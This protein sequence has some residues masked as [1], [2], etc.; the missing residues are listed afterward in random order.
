MTRTTSSHT[1]STFVLGALACALVACGGSSAESPP[2]A[3]PEPT[4]AAAP[5]D[6]APAPAAEPKES[7]AE[8]APAEPAKSDAASA[9]PAEKDVTREVKYV[10][11]SDGLKVEVEGT[12]FLVSAESKK[13]GAGWGVRV[14]VTAQAMDDGSHVLTN[15][16]VGPLAFA[17][18]VARGGSG[19]ATPEGEK[20]EG[21]GE[22]VVKKGKDVDF[23]RDWPGK[24]GKPLAIGDAIEIQMGLWGLGETK[25]TRRPVKKFAVVKMKVDKGTPRAKVEPPP[26]K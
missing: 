22:L 15:P 26:V 4:A 21:D 9:E 2:P 20:R 18:A 12:R 14:K 23:K 7:S 6:P 16:S 24:G 1:I 3:A 11:S 5:A 10:V 8:A 17:V 19:E 13:V 25:E